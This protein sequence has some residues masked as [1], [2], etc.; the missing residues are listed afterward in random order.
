MPLTPNFT[1]TQNYGLP[2]TIVIEDTSTGSDVSIVARRVFLQTATNTYL[3]PDGTTTDYVEW[4]STSGDTI[5][6]DA[7]D[8]DYCLNI[9]IQWVDVNG[10]VVEYKSALYVFT[11]YSEQYYYQLT[12]YQ[13]TTPNIVN[14]TNYYYNKMVLRVEIDSA[15][16]ACSIAGDIYGSQSCLDRAYY[17][18]SNANLFF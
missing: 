15:N 16:Q 3:V 10:T 12:Q 14:D 4:L 5:S 17:L 11:L 2:S 1:V 13:T 8:K 18:I 7:L 6:I 9:T